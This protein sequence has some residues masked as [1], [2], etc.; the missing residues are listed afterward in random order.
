MSVFGR[1]E[2]WLAVKP[3]V[4]VEG[5]ILVS[6]TSMLLQFLSLFSYRKIVKVYRDKQSVVIEIKRFWVTRHGMKIIPFDRINKILYEYD[7]MITSW[8][9]WYGA[10]DQVEC[11]TISL[12]LTRPAEKVR[13]FSFFGEGAVSTGMGGVILGD[14]DMFDYQ[15]DQEAT[16]RVY[17]KLLKVFTGKSLT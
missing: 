7:D 6:R 10:T 1:T 12:D 5:E 8:S 3:K 4:V 16:S 13:L 15:G 9:P 14:D 17:V 2:G 11:F